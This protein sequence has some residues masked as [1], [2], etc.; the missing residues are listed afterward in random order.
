MT[1]EIELKLH[2]TS[3]QLKRL[4][5]APWLNRYAC[6]PGRLQRLNSTY[7]DTDE[8]TLR[9]HRA[10]LR[11]RNVGD[12]FVQTFKAEDE[13]R[14]S[15]LGR[16]EWEC[17]LKKP[18]LDLKHAHMSETGGFRLKKLSG[19]LKPVFETR[20]RRYATPLRYHGSELELA[21]DEGEINARRRRLPIHEIEIELKRGKANHVIAVG[22]KIA[23][24]LKASY[25]STTKA[26]RGYVLR[27]NEAGRPSRAQDIFLAQHAKTGEAFKVI[28]MSCLRHFTA[29][30]D[31]V[32]G[33]EQEGVHQMRVGLR[34][35]RAAVSIFKKMLRGPETTVIKSQLKWLTEEL[36]PARDMEV[37]ADEA[38]SPMLD[39]S[40]V[41][42]AVEVLRTDIMRRRDAGMKR[43]QR[44]IQSE[45]YRKLVLETV[46]WINCG[47]WTKS[48]AAGRTLPIR[49][50]VTQEL[51]RRTKTILR[52]LGRVEKLSPL[53]RHKLRI[54]IKKLRYAIDYFRSLFHAK[55]RYHKFAV[56]LENLQASLGKLNDIR[57]HGELAKAYAMPKRSRRGAV[58]EAFAMG[59]LAGE[60]SLLSRGLIQT[61]KLL[62]RRLEDC[63][64]FW[65]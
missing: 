39:K 31:A 28:A 27:E 26:E 19:F 15:G 17:V 64:P 24:K 51:N 52:K 22:S 41:P 21:I 43:A 34:R 11:I 59:E 32:L 65:E 2:A 7:Y 1:E 48:R 56:T 37:L 63:R 45:S 50:F 60:E 57:V 35:L 33:G 25:G 29:N 49:R 30:R 13:A 6:G 10:A 3:A 36:G 12:H 46:F 18:K 14:R 4:R 9:G 42:K 47:R 54:A 40:P 38:I 61:T 20:V 62:G 58:S 53:Q 44:A 23:K 16:L 5:T 8:L 55:K